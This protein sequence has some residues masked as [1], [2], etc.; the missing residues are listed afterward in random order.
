[1]YTFVETKYHL[2]CM[3]EMH[4]SHSLTHAKD[5]PESDNLERQSL[6]R[7]TFKA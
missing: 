5:N 2:A 6:S 7:K 1:M 3:T 4:T